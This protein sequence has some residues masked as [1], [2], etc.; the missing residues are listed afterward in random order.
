[1]PRNWNG[2]AD[3]VLPPLTP[4]QRK[5]LSGWTDSYG[6]D[7]L[8]PVHRAPEIKYPSSRSRNPRF[9]VKVTGIPSDNLVQYFT[10]MERQLTSVLFSAARQAVNVC[11]SGLLGDAVE[12][13]ALQAGEGFPTAYRNHLKI[14]MNQVIPRIYVEQG[15]VSLNFTF[16]EVLGGWGALMYGAHQNALLD[17]PMDEENFK[18]YRKSTLSQL[19]RNPLPNYAEEEDLF[20]TKARR[21]EWWNTAVIDRT[22]TTKV[23]GNWN[24]RKPAIRQASDAWSVPDVP[25]FE[26][27]AND[28]VNVWVSKGVAPEWLILQHGTPAGSRPVVVPQDFTGKLRRVI[29]HAYKKIVDA[30]LFDFEKQMATEAT[31]LQKAYSGELVPVRA[32]R[33]V[34]FRETSRSFDFSDSLSLAK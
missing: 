30:Y 15:S 31:T 17:A 1:M 10:G 24:W 28:R 12:L 4:E 27:V 18:T 21:T 8:I 25:T 20:N 34:K 11:R 16:E 9:R 14:A 26:Q 7:R 19:P 6:N 29:Q 22:F 13:I 32:G 5:A 33:Y 23:G 3:P 2:P